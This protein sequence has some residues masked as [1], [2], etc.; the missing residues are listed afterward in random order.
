ME[1]KWKGKRAR[2]LKELENNPLVERACKKIGIARSTYYRWCKADI[3]FKHSAEQAQDKGRE[4][5]TDFVESKLLENISNNQFA[6]IAYWLSH[7]TARYRPYP[8]N[9]YMDE[10]K[11]LRIS[12]HTYRELTDLLKTEQ[13]YQIMRRFIANNR[14]LIDSHS[15][16]DDN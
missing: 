4:K 6:S 16:L 3:V 10:I 13:G 5:I 1:K 15:P 12:H 11:K 7:N 14:D 8:K 2:I 9:V